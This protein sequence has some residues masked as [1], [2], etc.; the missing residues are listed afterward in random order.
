M[1]RQTEDIERK[2]TVEAEERVTVPAGT[3]PTFRIICHNSRNNALVMTVWYA[4]EVR[5]I[6]REESALATGRQFRE[7]IAYKLR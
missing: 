1:A 7:L 3:F 2:C 5:H 4:P 6:V